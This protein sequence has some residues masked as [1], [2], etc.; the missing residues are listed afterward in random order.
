M[1]EYKYQTLQ[2][3]NLK[4]KL[5][6]EKQ[7]LYVLLG[8]NPEYAENRLI[9]YGVRPIKFWRDLRYR[10]ILSIDNLREQNGLSKIYNL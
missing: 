4:E 1:K 7:A 10:Q 5:L 9:E 2:N 8:R 6:E 3:K